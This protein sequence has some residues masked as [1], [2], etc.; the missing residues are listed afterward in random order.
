[1]TATL[2]DPAGNTSAPASTTVY[3]PN[4]VSTPPVVNPINDLDKV[5]TGTGTPGATIDLGEIKCTNLPIIVDAFGNWECKLTTPL[6]AGTVV[7]A[8]ATEPGRTPSGKVKQQVVLSATTSPSAPIVYPTMGFEVTGTGEPGAV[9]TVKDSKG[10]ILCSTTVQMDGTWSCTLE[11]SQPNGAVLTV[12]QMDSE[13][14]ISPPAHVKVDRT[15]PPAPTIDP[16]SSTDGVITGTGEPGNII[17]VTGVSCTNNPIVVDLK[18]KWKCILALPIQSGLT[19][20]VTQT[21]PA[22]NVSAPVTLSASDDLD[23]DGVSDAVEKGAPNGGDG[24]GDGIKDYLQANVLSVLNA[25]STAY[26]T[27]ELPSTGDCS[28]LVNYSVN[29]ENQIAK[30][31]SA[32]DYPVGL[33]NFKLKCSGVATIKQFWYG[34]Q[35]TTTFIARKYQTTTGAYKTLSNVNIS[36]TASALVFNY[37]IQEGSSLDDSPAG[38]GYVVDPIGPAVPAATTANTGNGYEVYFLIGMMMFTIGFALKKKF[39][40]SKY[41]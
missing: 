17:K 28:K 21:D 40:Y 14:N 34:L 39:N 19:I 13:G 15:A 18:G 20:T 29:K 37:Q 24:N 11:P 9:V 16:F 27:L 38:D 10:N 25:Y 36:K 4:N 22:G 35:L 12:T 41:C 3:D 5:I 6:P 23:G 2:T 31:D 33:L 1:V 32:Y 26:I 8:T 30:Q 7:I